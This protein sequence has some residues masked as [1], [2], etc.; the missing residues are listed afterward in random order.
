MHIRNGVFFDPLFFTRN[1]CFFDPL[2]FTWVIIKY[3]SATATILTSLFLEM[4]P[5]CANTMSKYGQKAVKKSLDK[6][7]IFAMH[8]S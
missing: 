3:R 2:F 7:R 6:V 5:K 8:K 4:T 1:G